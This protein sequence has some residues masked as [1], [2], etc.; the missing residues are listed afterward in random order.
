MLSPEQVLQLGV[1]LFTWIHEC[2]FFLKKKRKERKKKKSLGYRRLDLRGPAKVRR[3][4]AKNHTRVV[5]EKM[6]GRTRKSESTNSPARIFHHVLAPSFCSPQ[7]SSQIGSHIGTFATRQHSL[8][9]GTQ[10][11]YTYQII[12][13]YA[14]RRQVLGFRVSRLFQFCWQQDQRNKTRV[15]VTFVS[16]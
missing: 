5:A 15:Q 1:Q 16:T 14:P 2:T 9:L 6:W 3:C 13:V 11:S 8:D 12:S 10:D 4:H 7:A